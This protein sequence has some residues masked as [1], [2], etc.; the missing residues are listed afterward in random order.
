MERSCAAPLTRWRNANSGNDRPVTR[1]NMS[2]N[3]FRFIPQIRAASTTGINSRESRT[4]SINR[5][6]PSFAR[7]DMNE[8]PRSGTDHSSWAMRRSSRSFRCTHADCN[9]AFANRGRVSAFPMAGTSWRRSPGTRGRQFQRDP[10]RTEHDAGEPSRHLN[11][12]GLQHT[13]DGQ[14]PDRSEFG[15]GLLRRSPAH[16]HYHERD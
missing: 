5:L 16:R 14:V 8:S 3:E 9:S 15:A 13:A 2:E 7:P 4:A 11:S 10:L 12:R 6:I 1:L